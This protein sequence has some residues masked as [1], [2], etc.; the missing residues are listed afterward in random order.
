[1]EVP[2][3]KSEPVYRA[4]SI[5]SPVYEKAELAL[6]VQLVP[7]G[8]GSTYLHRLSVGDTVHFMGPYGEFRLSEDPE[9]EV[10]CVAGG[11]GLAPMKSII[12]S[13]LDRWPDRSCRLFYGCSSAV[14]AFHVQ[15][16]S[17]L[18]QQYPN[19]RFVCALSD[20]PG[21]A[22]RLKAQTGYVH[23]SVERDLDAGRRRQVY[24]CGPPEMLEKVTEV[25]RR[26]GTEEIFF[27]RF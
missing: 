7:R 24:L 1:V 13:V 19:F 21:D 12:Y 11:C 2:V 20:S 10:V 22:A 6:D 27:D 8:V 9:V 25:L 23:Q 17:R 15:L 14:D 26:K 4:Y 5:A 18:A 16:Y 3:R